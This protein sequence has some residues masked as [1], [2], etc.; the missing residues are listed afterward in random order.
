MSRC[1][2]VWVPSNEIFR[3]SLGSYTSN[4]KSWTRVKYWMYQQLFLIGQCTHNYFWL[5]NAP[6]TISDRSMYSQLFLIG[7]CTHN[8]FRLV[9]VPKTI[10]N[11]SQLVPVILIIHS[12]FWLV[13]IYTAIFDWVSTHCYFWL[14]DVCIAIYDWS[15]YHKLFLIGRI[16]NVIYFYR[17]VNTCLWG[18]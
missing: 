18:I 17:Y 10:S 6:T 2:L 7:Q 15:L 9:N 1:P 4:L 14:I 3:N 13:D 12:Y 16:F 11:W 8:F 5:V